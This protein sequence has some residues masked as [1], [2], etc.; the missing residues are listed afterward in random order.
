[1]DQ[2]FIMY[3]TKEI[4]HLLTVRT[5]LKKKLV[6]LY[7]L[8]YFAYNALN[9]KSLFSP[10][11]K[12]VLNNCYPNKHIPFSLAFPQSVSSGNATKDLIREFQT[13]LKSVF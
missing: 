11:P 12:F 3:N 13:I 2:H 4:I 9:K 10:K 7:W 1:M 5:I 6:F 8:E